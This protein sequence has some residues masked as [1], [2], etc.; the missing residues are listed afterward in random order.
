MRD[1][2]TNAEGWPRV[3]YFLA[4]GQTTTGLELYVKIGRE[5]TENDQ[6]A[7]YK[8]MDELEKDLSAESAR[9]NPDNIAWKAAWLVK[10]TEMFTAAKLAPVYVKEIDNEYCGSRCCPH[11]VWCLVT[12]RLGVIKIGWRK[13]V[14]V[15]DWYASDCLLT[16]DEVSSDDVTK[17]DRDIHAHGYEKA[18]EYLTKIGGYV[19][20]SSERKEWIA[21]L[22][23]LRNLFVACCDVKNEYDLHNGNRDPSTAIAF[24]KAVEEAR[25]RVKL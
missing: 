4:S 23:V 22:V 3:H 13:S 2:V 15:I 16:P 14:I 17:G 10:V 24:D 12:T 19:M 8:W 1:I 11:R 18:T 5:L 25:K 9:L 20:E 21:D 6:R 7:I